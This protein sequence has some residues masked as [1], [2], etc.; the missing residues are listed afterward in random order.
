MRFYPRGELTVTILESLSIFADSPPPAGMPLPSH[1]DIPEH[2]L[3]PCVATGALLATG[4]L[5]AC[6]SREDLSRAFWHFARALRAGDITRQEWAES[7]LQ[8]WH[9]AQAAGA[10]LNARLREIALSN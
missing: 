4:D 2:V 10:E 8:V 3:W 5:G 7:S 1:P 6:T 9:E